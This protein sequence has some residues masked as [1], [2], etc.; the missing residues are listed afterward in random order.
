MNRIHSFKDAYE[1]AR[2]EC[3]VQDSAHKALRAAFPEAVNVTLSQVYA[4]DGPLGLWD[5]VVYFDGGTSLKATSTTAVG[6]G[7]T[8]VYAHATPR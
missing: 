4:W 1:K 3:S 2:V 8:L 7:E 5:A 6:A